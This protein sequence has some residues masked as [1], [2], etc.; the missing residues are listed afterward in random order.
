MKIS[1]AY[2]IKKFHILLQK[3]LTFVQ[4]TNFFAKHFILEHVLNTAVVLVMLAKL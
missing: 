3:L 1:W 2:P 4:K